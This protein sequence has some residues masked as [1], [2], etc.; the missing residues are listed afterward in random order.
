ML[1][2][3]CG[4]WHVYILKHAITIAPSSLIPTILHDFDD[5]KG[6]EETIHTF[7]AMKRYYWLPKLWQYIVKFI[8]KCSV[9]AKIDQTWEGTHINIWKYHKYQWQV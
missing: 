3:M 6:N 8:G 2:Q 9:C 5:P 1:S 4:S 7:E